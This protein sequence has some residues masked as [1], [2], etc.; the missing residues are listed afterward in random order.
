MEQQKKATSYLSIS[1]MVCGIISI[2]LPMAGFNIVV[3]I[4]AI[5][6]GV[7]GKN[8]VINNQKDGLGFAKAGIICGI[9]GIVIWILLLIVIS[10]TLHA[11]L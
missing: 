4:I 9:I 11:F 10:S 1:S 5:V 2:I 6:L 3:G 7:I 8:D